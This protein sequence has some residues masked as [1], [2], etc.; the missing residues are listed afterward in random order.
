VI[1]LPFGEST[2]PPTGTPDFEQMHLLETAV[3]MW[4]K[5]IKVSDIRKFR[6]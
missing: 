6:L 1:P 2:A 4:T 3:I 5:Q